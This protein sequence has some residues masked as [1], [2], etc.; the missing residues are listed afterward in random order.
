MRCTCG[1]A[2][3]EARNAALEEAAARCDEA[4][5]FRST[6][7]QYEMMIQAN[8]L[9]EDFRAMKAYDLKPTVAEL[10]ELTKLA[11]RIAELEDHLSQ[12]ATTGTAH[13]A[14]RGMSS[15]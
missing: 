10:R 15:T 8:Y 13:A 6:H 7:A 12:T 9:A 11:Q 14:M 5:A 1:T 3:R 4:S 2:S